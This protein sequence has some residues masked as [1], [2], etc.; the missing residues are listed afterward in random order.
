MA[1]L[2][3]GSQYLKDPIICSMNM[4]QYYYVGD[5]IQTKASLLARSSLKT[6]WTPTATSTPHTPWRMWGKGRCRQVV[7]TPCRVGTP[8]LPRHP[9]VHQVSD[10]LHQKGMMSHFTGV[11]ITLTFQYLLFRYYQWVNLVLLLQACCFYLPRLVA[12]ATD[13]TDIVFLRYMWRGF[14]NSTLKHLQQELYN[15]VQVGKLANQSI[16][17]RQDVAQ[18]KAQ[19]TRVVHYLSVS[20]ARKHYI[21]F[22]YPLYCINKSDTE[23]GGKC[24]IYILKI[25]F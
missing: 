15:P 19:M 14:E 2:V 18:K 11:Q 12:R 1:I 9:H 24:A 23:K 20:E 22:F 16:S 7:S 4:K 21:N 5:I 3:T 10:Q 8:G 17:Y 25:K 6:C 13:G